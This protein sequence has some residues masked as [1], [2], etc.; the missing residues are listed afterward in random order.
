MEFGFFD[1]RDDG[2][3]S[4]IGFVEISLIFA[5]QDDCFYETISFDRVS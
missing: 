2:E 4:G 3:H 5:S 1:G